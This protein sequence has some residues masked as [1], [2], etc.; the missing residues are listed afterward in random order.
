MHIK[1]LKLVTVAIALAGVAQAGAFAVFAGGA[2]RPAA[3]VAQSGPVLS[4]DPW[5]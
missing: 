2:A 4:N 5:D 1:G 3:T